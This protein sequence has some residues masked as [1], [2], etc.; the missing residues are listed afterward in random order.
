M[1]DKILEG[2]WDISVI[3]MWSVKIKFYRMIVM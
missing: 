3:V 2:D 1:D